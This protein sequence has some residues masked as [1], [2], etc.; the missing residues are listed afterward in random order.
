MAGPDEEETRAETLQVAVRVRP[1]MPSEED[2]K[3]AATVKGNSIN[4]KGSKHN[5]TCQYDTVCFSETPTQDD[6][7]GTNWRKI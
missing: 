3:S 6:D 4:V 5:N 7:L 2:S 1:T